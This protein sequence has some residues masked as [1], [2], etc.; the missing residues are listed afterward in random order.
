VSVLP[1]LRHT[2]T[3]CCTHT[4]TRRAAVF[5]GGRYD[6]FRQTRNSLF[7]VGLPVCERQSE[8]S[9]RRFRS[10]A[11]VCAR[12][13]SSPTMFPRDVSATGSFRLTSVPRRSCQLILL[14]NRCEPFYKICP[15]GLVTPR[16]LLVPLPT[17]SFA[18]QVINIVLGVVALWLV[19]K[20][21]EKKPPGRPIPGP[22]G[23]PIIGNLLDVPNEV[24]YKV[25]S[26]WRQKYGERV[27]HSVPNLEG[28]IINSSLL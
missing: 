24:E 23:W 28:F 2:T 4:T 3:A 20:V 15:S 27:N 1:Y 9:L 17:M 8:Y 26:Q 6:M 11:P 22:K 10:S 25:F 19:K 7:Q 14:S 16:V 5:S 12:A 21:T 18:V 13:I